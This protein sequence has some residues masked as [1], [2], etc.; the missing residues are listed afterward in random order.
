M[1]EGGGKHWYL[2]VHVTFATVD[3]NHDMVSSVRG[4]G[5]PNSSANLSLQGHVRTLW[6]IIHLH[7]YI[8]RL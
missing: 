8:Y 7:I 4:G 2:S 1:E 5:F 6:L 3:R